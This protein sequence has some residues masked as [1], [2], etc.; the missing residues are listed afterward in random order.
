MDEFVNSIGNIGNFSKDFVDE[1]SSI[2]QN[3]LELEGLDWQLD[4]VRFTEYFSTMEYLIPQSMQMQ[5]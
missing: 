3:F 4:P 5:M 2:P 1:L